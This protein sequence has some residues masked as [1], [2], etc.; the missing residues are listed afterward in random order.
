MKLAALSLASSSL[1]AFAVLRKSAE[2]LF[3]W[4]GAF[5]DIEL[6][7]DHLPRDAGHGRGSPREYVP[8]GTEES[9]ER[10]FLFRV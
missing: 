3:Y 5:L 6:V 4:L 2:S 8:V 7:L 10:A 9:D 1:M